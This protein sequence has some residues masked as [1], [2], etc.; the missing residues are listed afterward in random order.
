MGT[1]YKCAPRIECF[2]QKSGFHL[3]KTIF[4]KTKALFLRKFYR[5][6]CYQKN[7]FLKMH[8]NKLIQLLQTFS[9]K[10]RK[11][12]KRFVRSPMV[13]TN[14]RCVALLEILLKKIPPYV[15]NQAKKAMLDEEA[16]KLEKATIFKK[17]FPDQELEKEGIESSNLR[18]T[19]S[20][21]YHLAKEFLV[22]QRQQGENTQ[23]KPATYYRYVLLGEL[24][25]RKTPKLF[26]S[27]YKNACKELEQQKNRDADFYEASYQ[28]ELA[29]YSY[30]INQES[31]AG[32]LDLQKLLTTFDI[33]Y[34]TRKLYLCCAAI[35]NQRVTLFE[36]DHL[37]FDNLARDMKQ[38]SLQREPIVA[39]Y[40]RLFLMLWESENTAHY[41]HFK[42]SLAIIEQEEVLGKQRL[43]QIYTMMVN[44]FLRKISKGEYQYTALA[45]GMYQDMEKRGF[46]LNQSGEIS[47]GKVKNSTVL[48]L[49]LGEF[50][51]VKWFIDTYSQK[52][53]PQFRTSVYAYNMALWHFFK[54]NYDK[55]H[56]LL[57]A[58]QDIDLYY[59][60][61]W[62]CLLLKIYYEQNETEAF[63]GLERSLRSF[64]HS[65]KKVAVKRRYTLFVQ[66]AKGLFC[67]KHPIYKTKKSKPLAILWEKIQAA[68]SLSERR[69]L[70]EKA[71][72]S[73]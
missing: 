73:M 9:K 4:L 39:F 12:F 67:C 7:T 63:F 3:K 31:R 38:H 13:N 8:N 20:R 44:Y 11:A 68:E 25:R 72:A 49:S 40:Y 34:L 53:A 2:C 5:P 27:E 18:V 56:L 17:L 66:M 43:S 58:V 70:M 64:I 57:R 54:K 32:N 6:D 61:D 10:E 26:Q 69:W 24:L 47:P 55:A 1:H 33:Y 35:L 28:L 14:E 16:T 23:A 71:K 50:E 42:Q 36:H 62:R 45:F 65:K 19:R 22:F 52:A 37:A 51:W 41:T 60:L 46:L 59:A 48:G 15:P 29:K 21:L 30:I